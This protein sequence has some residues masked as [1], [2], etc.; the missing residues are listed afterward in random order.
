MPRKTSPRRSLPT[1]AL[2][3]DRSPE[4][5]GGIVPQPVARFGADVPADYAD[6]LEAIKADIRT[7]QVRA[8]AA[9]NREL[10]ALYWRIGGAIIA[11]QA[12]AGW[13]SRVLDRLAADLQRT[14][15]G[16]EGL[17]RRNLYRM[18]AFRLAYASVYASASPP[19]AAVPDG[20]GTAPD[21]A[22][23]AIVPQ[24][25]AQLPWGHNVLLL[26]RV[27]DADARLWYARAAAEHGWSR[28]VLTLQLDARLHERQGRAVT[29]FAR[30]LPAVDSDLAAQVL[31]DPYLFDFLTLAGDARERE[32]ERGLMA[33]VERFLLELGAGFAFVGRQ[34]HL[35]V[36]D[37]DFYVD[38]LFY[39]LTLRCYVLIDLKAVPFRPEFTGQLNFYCAVVDDR[40]RKAGD[41][42][43]IGLL[44]CKGKNRL[45]A[46][47]AL[48]GV[49]TP[50]GVADWTEQLT[51]ALPD[52]FKGSLPTVEELERELGVV[53]G[54]DA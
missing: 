23:G 9:A 31:K 39:H 7:T 40:L 49:T 8:A 54:K 17:S 53:P 33:H 52:A 16:V 45:V 43:T 6:V 51:A 30:T 14:F 32:L 35:D 41:A 44:L 25:V 50:I 19:A 47:Y 37:A 11:R 29:N 12:A 13:G 21:A 42:P 46:E 18:R 4:S 34:V 38:L 26:E 36:G 28:A 20:S 48:R 24:A 1:P 5:A 10:I 22:S 15:P 3:G 2:P 27:K